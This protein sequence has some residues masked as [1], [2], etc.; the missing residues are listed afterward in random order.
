MQLINQ[1]T[2]VKRVDGT[3]WSSRRRAVSSLIKTYE[4]VLDTLAYIDSSD[5][6][7]AGANAK[8]LLI[9]IE[10]FEFQFVLRVLNDAFE[11]TGLLSDSLQSN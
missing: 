10:E 2:S 5:K 4:F 3:R 8:P 7:P 6:T 11:R 1:P 9:S